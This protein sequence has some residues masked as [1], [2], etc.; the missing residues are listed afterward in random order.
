[1]CAAIDKANPN[2]WYFYE[3]YASEEVYQAHRMTSH[4]KEYIELTAEMTTY[5]EAITIEPGL[6][7]NKDYLRY[8]IK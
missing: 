2:R 8:E 7:M 1:M 5:K 6:F 4:F 3:I